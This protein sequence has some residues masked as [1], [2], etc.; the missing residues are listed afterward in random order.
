MKT[1]NNVMTDG[2]ESYSARGVPRMFPAV[3]HRWA[4]CIAAQGSTSKVT[5]SGRCNCTGMLKIKLFRK[6]H[7]HISY[8]D[9]L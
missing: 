3:E 2:T 5:L 7:T 8:T 1:L 6:L 4:K 9:M